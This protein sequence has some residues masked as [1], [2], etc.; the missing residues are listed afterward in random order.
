MSPDPTT[1]K[2]GLLMPPSRDR[3]TDAV[4]KTTPVDSLVSCCAA[5]G[6]RTLPRRVAAVG[7]EDMAGVEVG[8]L[9]GEEQ[10]RS[11][12]GGRLAQ[13]A[14]RHA[15]HEI[16]AHLLGI[17][18]VLEHPLGERRAEHGRTERIYG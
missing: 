14:L 3:A 18:V 13:P 4:Q 9:R 8:R 2:R 6:T 12:K 16:L 10:K 17:V 5:P 1:E 7:V 15:A 11:G